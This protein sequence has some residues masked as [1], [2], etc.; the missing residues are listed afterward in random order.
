[1]LIIGERINCTRKKMGQAAQDRDIAFIQ[2]EAVK[3]VQS[4]A[5]VLDVNGGV[6][7]Q[8]QE[9]LPWLVTIV[10]EAVD[11]PLCLDSADPEALRRALPLCRKRA[12]INSITDEH[13]RF[14]AI[15]PLVKE[16]D[17]DV[18]ALCMSDNGPPSGFD[19]RI[20]TANR[21]IES[22][23]AGG[24]NFERIYLD[25][26][27]FPLGVGAGHT[28]SMLEAVSRISSLYPEVHKCCG[29][30]NVSHG[31]PARK[32]LNEAYLMM[33][34]SCGLDAAILDPTDPRL[35]ARITA[36]NALL[37]KDEYC[38][39][40]LKAFRSGKFEGLV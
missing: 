35:M 15:F 5:H 22:L 11:V 34:M 37:G 20:E 38:M 24:V 27:I 28:V 6:P 3:Q 14:T 4:G 1:L 23:Q 29:L 17:T 40:Y 13:D 8:E 25:A 19:D 10:Q 33:L 2:E 32:L 26:C 7:G 9:I 30:S 39:E 31:L 21:L 12:I 36:A 16:F 18:I